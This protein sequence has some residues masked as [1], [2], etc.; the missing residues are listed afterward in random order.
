MKQSDKGPELS[1]AEW[2][3]QQVAE[4]ARRREGYL[5]MERVLKEVLEHAAAKYAPLA[6]V[7]ARAKAI[8]SFAEKALRKCE[9]YRDPVDRMT[10]LCGARVIVHTQEQVER[11]SRFLEQY[12][13]VDWDNSEDIGRRLKT[14]EFGYRSVHYIVTFRRGVFPTSDIPVRVPA[15]LYGGKRG[16]RNPR[17]EVQVR[18]LMQH[19]WADVGHDLL[20]K[21]GF[22]APEVWEREYARLAAML[23]TA[24]GVFGSVHGGLRRFLSSY[25]AYMTPEQMAAELKT[26]QAVQ[27][28]DPGNVG[29]ALRIA[30]VA[31][32]AEQWEAA[33]AALEPH[34]RRDEQ[35]AAR[36]PNSRPQEPAVL[37]ELGLACCGKGRPA[38]RGALYKRGQRLLEQSAGDPDEGAAAL[39]C[40]AASWRDVDDKRA[41]AAFAR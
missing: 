13:R 4:F 5:L 29:L 22:R 14:T 15:R 31:N 33:I 20:Y 39:L 28:H 34:A 11:I 18:T 21:G 8:P 7:T 41:R 38:P 26:L 19:A 25:R 1:K 2:L 6:I 36:D 9:K 23:E 37:R 32:A 16:M 35:R 27:E 40:L 3:A 12:F 17:A 10:D 30:G 24:D